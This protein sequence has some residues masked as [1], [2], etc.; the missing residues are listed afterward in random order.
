MR[1]VDAVGDLPEQVH[2]TLD[3]QSSLSTEQAMKRLALDIFHDEVK[4]AFTSLAKVGDADRVRMLDR[5]GRLGLAFETG[6]GLALGQIV[7]AE[8]VGTDGLYRNSAGREFLIGGEIDLA[9][10]SA[11]EAAFEQI[12]LGEKLWPLECDLG[13]RLVVRA[14]TDL[15]T[16]TKLAF[17]TLTHLPMDIL[18]VRK[19]LSK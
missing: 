9:H 5:R 19:Q 1:G 14:N 17:G 8:N 11:A 4:R 2:G 13:R 15:V 16:E 18:P 7:A 3:G 6:D 10:R 12:T